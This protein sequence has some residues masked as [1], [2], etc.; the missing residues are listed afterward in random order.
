MSSRR[1][2][3]M[4]I[5]MLLTLVIGLLVGV[6]MSRSGQRTVIVREQ[7][8]AYSTSHR[9]RGVKEMVAAWLK[10]SAEQDLLSMTGGGLSGGEAFT[11]Q[12]GRH[13]SITVRVEPA[14]STARINPIGLNTS[15]GL[16]ARRV[17]AILR[18]RFG[19]RG[20]RSRTR[21]V[22]PASIDANRASDDV[23]AALA[24]AVL[25]SREA[26]DRFVGAL[27][28][29]ETIDGLNA[30]DVRNAAQSVNIDE[31]QADRLS[32]LFGARPTL[33]RVR[34]TWVGRDPLQS[35]PDRRVVYEGLVSLETGDRAS[36]GAQHPSE[37]FLE[38]GRADEA[39]GY[40]DRTD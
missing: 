23:A 8:D 10:Y 4:P 39:D 14:Q 30:A 17:E 36:F 6:V 12:L 7:L 16:A 25:E 35:R 21:T 24:E 15:D 13:D 28:Q 19:E 27:R 18:E 5:I 2:F 40:T 9:E 26:A 1:G 38:W 33:W 32:M 11:A 37:L 3:V 20:L 22:G 34:A 31:N 29:I